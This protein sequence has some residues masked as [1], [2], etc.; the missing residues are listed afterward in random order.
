MEANKAHWERIFSTKQANEVSWTQEIPATSLQ[1][2]HGFNVPKSARVIDIGGGDGK[3][4]DFLLEE[5]YEHITVL[6]IS[7]VAL[8][9]ARKRLGPKADQVTWIVGD[10]TAFRPSRP[11][12]VWHDRAAFHF[13]TTGPEVAAYLE[14]A[15][16]S[17][18]AEGFMTIG[19]FSTEGPSKC[20]G[21]PVRRYSEGTLVNEMSKGFEKL[22]CLTEDHE[23]PFHTKQNFLFCSFKRINA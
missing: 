2:I 12:D 17:I 15:R 20:S 6:D 16:S 3:L 19:T 13:L 9:R 22:R 14:I 11:Y 4:V 7:S 5:G 8:E 18:R 21:L 1:F 23:T 10:I